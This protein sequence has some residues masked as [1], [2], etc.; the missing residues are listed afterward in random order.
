MARKI[1]G[2]TRVKPKPEPKSETPKRAKRGR[3]KQ[4]LT[5]AQ[6]RDKVRG[7]VGTAYLQAMGG[8]SVGSTRKA[9][10]FMTRVLTAFYRAME[11]RDDHFAPE[12]IEDLIGEAYENMG[13]K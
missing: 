3:H 8:L 12:E 10:E 9:T 2:L 13:S 6:R 5:K 4:A 7:A 1:R 11:A